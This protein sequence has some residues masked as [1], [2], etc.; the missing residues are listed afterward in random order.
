MKERQAWL[1]GDTPPLADTWYT[2]WIRA[3]YGKA[4]RDLSGRNHRTYRRWTLESRCSRATFPRH[5]AVLRTEAWHWR[6]HPTNAFPT[7]PPSA[8]PA[9][10]PAHRGSRQPP[11]RGKTGYRPRRIP[12]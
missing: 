6:D 2:M 11:A 5:E 12:T 3:Y 9:E 8:V 4:S 10:P 1:H 7:T